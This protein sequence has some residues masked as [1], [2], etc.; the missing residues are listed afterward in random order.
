[1]SVPRHPIPSK[2]WKQSR[3]D[4]LQPR[5]SG[6]NWSRETADVCF[7]RQGCRDYLL[8]PWQSSWPF[9]TV[10]SKC[11]FPFVWQPSAISGAAP[12]KSGVPH[13]REALHLP[14]RWSRLIARQKE[15][16]PP[17][18]PYRLK[19]KGKWIQPQL[20]PLTMK[21]KF[22]ECNNLQNGVQTCAMDIKGFD[23]LWRIYSIWIHY[24]PSD[25]KGA[26]ITT[27]KPKEDE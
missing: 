2:A 23:G 3:S 1:M 5:L 16:F 27:H 11:F 19:T 10:G 18:E 15:M 8:L 4:A 6:G 12:Q 14:S 26:E 7:Y 9:R 24:R 13:I 25:R 20:I 22:I 17:P 21:Q